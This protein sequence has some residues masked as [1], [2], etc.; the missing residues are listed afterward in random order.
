MFEYFREGQVPECEDVED[1]IDIFNAAGS[2][3][4]E[5]EPESDPDADPETEEEAE[6]DDE[7]LF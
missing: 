5:P 7:P 6:E 4:P 1:V 3:D 2:L